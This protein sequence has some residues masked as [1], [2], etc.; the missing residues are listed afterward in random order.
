MKKFHLT[1]GLILVIIFLLTG[2]YMDRFYH[3]L[4]EMADGPRMLYRSRH[5]YILLSGLVH[6]CIGSYFHYRL[7]PWLRTVQVLGSALLTIG[8]VILVGA[9]FY[10]PRLTNLANPLTLLG[11]IMTAVG[12]LLH[13]LSGL[14]AAEQQR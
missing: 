1:F 11:I 9:F 12:T 10:E 13:L 14:G 8:S 2:Q 3:H 4:S 6:L 7:H 5:I